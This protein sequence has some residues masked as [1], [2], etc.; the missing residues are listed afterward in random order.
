[1]LTKCH[2]G[3]VSHS[4][5]LAEKLEQTG[6]KRIV[7]I[8]NHLRFSRDGNPSFGRNV[9]VIIDV[10]KCAFYLMSNS[11]RQEVEYD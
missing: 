2:R 8:S 11:L 5:S 7:Q 4:E 1:M 9:K 6:K 10:A 3:H